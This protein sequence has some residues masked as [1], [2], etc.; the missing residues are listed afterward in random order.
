MGSSHRRVA[1]AL[2]ACHVTAVLAARAGL[3]EMMQEEVGANVTAGGV[4]CA[5][6]DND[7]DAPEGTFSTFKWKD[8]DK[9]KK[10]FH[11]THVEKVSSKCCNP[12]SQTPG[13]ITFAEESQDCLPDGNPRATKISCWDYHK[14]TLA[15][16]NKCT[17][18]TDLDGNEMQ[19]GVITEDVEGKEAVLSSYWEQ[20]QFHET[21]CGPDYNHPITFMSRYCVCIPRWQTPDGL[22]V[23]DRSGGLMV[24]TWSYINNGPAVINTKWE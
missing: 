9:C 8:G 3:E 13:A 12:R 7:P 22:I 2:A 4:C 5:A 16:N 14:A 10:A 6:K 11:N 17:C 19:V 21:T 20:V 24:Q 18:S 1:A 15:K 23:P